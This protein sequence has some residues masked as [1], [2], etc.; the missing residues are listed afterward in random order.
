MWNGSHE[1]GSAQG[2]CLLLYK[3]EPQD[4]CHYKDSSVYK[5]KTDVAY[6]NMD[7]VLLCHSFLFIN[8][9]S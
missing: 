1:L 4:S 9:V 2:R 8:N 7:C 3:V 6:N 5:D